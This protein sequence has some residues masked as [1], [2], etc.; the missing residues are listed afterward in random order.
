MW[1]VV[2]CYDSVGEERWRRTVVARSHCEQRDRW[3]SDV[4]LRPAQQLDHT[5]RTPAAVPRNSDHVTVDHQAKSI[6]L[7]DIFRPIYP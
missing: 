3:P 6:K 1:R 5:H 2:R 7:K 4:L